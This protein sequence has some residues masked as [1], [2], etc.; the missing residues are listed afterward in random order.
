MSG[1]YQDVGEGIESGHLSVGAQGQTGGEIDDAAAFD[2]VERHDD[3]HDSFSAKG[4]GEFDRVVEFHG[5][6]NFEAIIGI[7]CAYQRD[8]H[9]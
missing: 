4:H 6:E 7:A 2:F 5:M 9:H 3:Y 8:A 1:G